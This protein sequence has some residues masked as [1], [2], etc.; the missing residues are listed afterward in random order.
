VVSTS[1]E[2]V[3][4]LAGAEAGTS[5]RVEDG[6]Y[7]GNFVLTASGTQQAPVELCGSPDAVLDGGAV[8]GGYTMHLDGAAY[9]RVIG[10]SLRGGQ[11]GLMADGAVGNV[12]DGI[13]VTDVGDEAIHLRSH[14]TDNV[15]QGTTIR[16]TGLRREKFGEGLYIGSAES[17]WCDL[18]DCEPDRSDRNVLQGND[19]AGTTSEA[20][21]IKE[22]TT[23]GVLRDNTFSGESISAVDSWVDVKGNSWEI[24]GN[25]GDDA[26]EDGFQVHEIL[27]GWGEYNVFSQ[28]VAN[29]DADGYGFN[30]TKR[31]DGNTVM[32][33]NSVSG[34]DE[35]LATIDCT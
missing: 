16:N 30:V 35:G 19:I 22:G 28:N 3:T 10:L 33:S 20:V 27:D 2:L 18:T 12:I 13:S 14:S 34:A 17:N 15:V 26:P 32:C 21:D 23:D 11:K 25:E 7:P 8:D 4:A 24:T 1:D 31:D 6:S 5:I 9:W 29:V